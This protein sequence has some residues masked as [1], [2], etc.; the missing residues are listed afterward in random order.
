MRMSKKSRRRPTKVGRMHPVK[1][2][3]HT[4]ELDALD[5]A[6]EERDRSRAEIIRLAV[7][8]Y[9]QIED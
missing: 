9:L 8:K 4:D 3:F 5:K 2:L 7:R 1:A 6:A